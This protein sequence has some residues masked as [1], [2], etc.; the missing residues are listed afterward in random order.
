MTVVG[1]AADGLD[2][3]RMCE[4][5]Q[6]DLLILDIA[7]PKFNGIESRRAAETPASRRA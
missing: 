5:H 1:E 6:P 3:L 7:M 2:A 4:E